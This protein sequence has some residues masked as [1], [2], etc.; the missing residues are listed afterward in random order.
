ML[1]DERVG[2][3]NPPGGSAG[4]QVER[5][6][7]PSALQ[8][9]LLVRS[10]DKGRFCDVRGRWR[11]CTATLWRCSCSPIVERQRDAPE[12]TPEAFRLADRAGSRRRRTRRPAA[13]RSGRLLVRHDPLP[14]VGRHRR[15]TA[16]RRSTTC[17]TRAAT[18]CSS[19]SRSR[20]WPPTADSTRRCRSSARTID[21]L[22]RRGR[23]MVRSLADL[24]VLVGHDPGLPRA[25]RRRSRRPGCASRSMT[26]AI[27]RIV[28]A[29]HAAIH[30]WERAVDASTS[31]S[32]VTTPGCG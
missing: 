3:G 25:S 7:A 20:T 2:G 11:L 30:P 17:S 8:N 6:S 10:F 29:G 9:Y 16:C 15:A 1:L 21:E 19:T 14:A 18:G 5:S 4:G 31:S 26:P 24:V 32:V 28:A 12:N 23:A 22:R 13:S 27:E